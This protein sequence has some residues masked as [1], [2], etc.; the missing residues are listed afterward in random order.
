MY[1]HMNVERCGNVP[2][3]ILQIANFFFQFLSG[4]E[5]HNRKWFLFMILKLH[6]LFL[7]SYFS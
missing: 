3:R 7:P 2:D 4:M 5:H 1:L 6:I